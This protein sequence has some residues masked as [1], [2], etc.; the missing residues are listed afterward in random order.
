MV[1]TLQRKMFASISFN[2]ANGSLRAQDMDDFV[3][4]I[5]LSGFANFEEDS[6]FGK[7]VHRMGEKT[8]ITS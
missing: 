4:Q 8:H 2:P 6:D 3:T 5:E 1:K 7:L